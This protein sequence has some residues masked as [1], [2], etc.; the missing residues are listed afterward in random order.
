MLGQEGVKSSPAGAFVDSQ[1]MRGGL[2][3]GRSGRHRFYRMGRLFLGI[4]LLQWPKNGRTSECQVKTQ[5]EPTGIT[6]IPN[7]KEICDNCKA[8][9]SMSATHF[10]GHRVS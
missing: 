3:P 1:E 5:I 2:G 8:L 6:P 10:R 7:K 4:F 9:N